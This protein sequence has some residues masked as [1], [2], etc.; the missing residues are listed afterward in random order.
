M[1]LNSLPNRLFLFL[2]MTFSL[3]D[4]FKLSNLA[5][6]IILRCSDFFKKYGF[7]CSPF[8]IFAICSLLWS[9]KIL[10]LKS[11]FFNVS[12]LD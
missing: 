4:D 5:F 2:S 9:F 7:T 8:L 1:A 3:C 12:S 11:R 10:L 6:W